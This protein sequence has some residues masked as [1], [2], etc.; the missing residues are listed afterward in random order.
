MTVIRDVTLRDGLQLAGTVLPTE[1]K[2]DLARALLDAGIPELEI[3]SLANPRL[4]PP[5]A[6][7]LDVVAALTDEELA[8]CWVWVATP[9]HVRRALDAGIRN[10]QYCLSVSDAHNQANLGRDTETSLSA[11]P[12]SVEAVQAAGGR[13]ELCLATSFTCPFDGPVDPGRVLA[14]ARDPRAEGTEDIVLCDTLG[15]AIP[16]EVGALVRRVREDTPARRIVFHSHDTWGQGLANAFA[17][18]AAGAEMV[19]GTLG[20]LGGCPFAPGAGGN[21]STEDLAFGL[22]PDWLTPEVL[23][24]LVVL[25]ENLLAALGE[26]SRSRAAAAVRATPPVF[27]WAAGYR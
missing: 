7:T 25:Q 2:I 8:R 10:L 15:Q 11:L 9:G 1:A 23:A 12:E 24:R 21:T 3:G 19:D 5:M 14:I 13:I 6:G 26:P 22:R 27:R 16:T 18:V 4:V 20:A 17:A